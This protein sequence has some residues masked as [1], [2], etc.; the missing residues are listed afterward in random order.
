MF[1]NNK[2]YIKYIMNIKSN[3]LN[4]AT[5]LAIGLAFLLVNFSPKEGFDNAK[6]KHLVFF[7]WKDCGYCKKFMPDWKEFV[8]ET[9]SETI[10]LKAIEKDEDPVLIEKL[11]IT[12]YPTLMLLDSQMNKIKTFNGDRTKTALKAFITENE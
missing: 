6:T 2:M 4:I 5:L 3:L 9:Q 10:G 12:G 8:K 11:G 1:M 7:H